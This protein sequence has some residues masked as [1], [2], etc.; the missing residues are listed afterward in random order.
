MSELIKSPHESSSK[1]HVFWDCLYLEKR[2]VTDSYISKVKAALMMYEQMLNKNYLT[3]RQN[4]TT[5]GEE[6]IELY[7]GNR[8]FDDIK[9][10]VEKVIMPHVSRPERAEAKDLRAVFRLKL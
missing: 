4:L 9:R 7:P 3:C 6:F 10:M 1:S 2:E 5:A 8:L